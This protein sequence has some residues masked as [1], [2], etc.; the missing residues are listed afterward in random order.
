MQGQESCELK[1]EEEATQSV[2][3]T[4]ES[5]HK[6]D[7]NDN[8]MDVDDFVQ[9]AKA[10]SAQNTVRNVTGYIASAVFWLHKD[11]GFENFHCDKC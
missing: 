4:D 9:S 6:S 7:S 10:I 11:C 3:F 2:D 1:A 5:L 8:N